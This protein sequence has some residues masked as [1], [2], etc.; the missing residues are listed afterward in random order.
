V[1][2]AYLSENTVQLAGHEL[3]GDF[4]VFGHHAAS[5]ASLRITSL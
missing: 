2:D 4:L 3:E 5:R 1:Y